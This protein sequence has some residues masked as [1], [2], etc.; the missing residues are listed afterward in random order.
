MIFKRISR[1]DPERVFV[2]CKNG[3]ASTVTNGQPV[4]WDMSA[5][6]GVTID[7]SGAAFKRYECICRDYRGE[8]RNRRI[9][10]DAGLRLSCF[11]ACGLFDNREGYLDR[12][13][14]VFFGECF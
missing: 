11:G 14:F 13:T 2:V 4:Q 12:R 7:I 10:S 6:D 3:Y 9:W 5:A 8:Y 1:A